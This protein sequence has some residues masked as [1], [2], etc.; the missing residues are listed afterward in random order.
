MDL[1]LII[2]IAVI[3][4]AII[5]FIFGFSNCNNEESGNSGVSQQENS[6]EYQQPE[7]IYY[8]YDNFTYQLI[9]EE[10]EVVSIHNFE[11]K[12]AVL[13]S[14]INGKRVASVKENLFADYFMMND[15]HYR[16][17]LQDW[18]AIHFPSRDSNPLTNEAKLFI[19]ETL[20]TELYIDGF[21]IG[22][23]AFHD[24]LHLTKLT[25]GEGVNSIG[26]WAFSHCFNL[27][28]VVISSNDIII[29]EC[30]FNYCE[31]L[32]SLAVSS[33]VKSFG[34]DCFY[35]ANSLTE[36]N[37]SGSIEE[38]ANIDFANS[39]STPL[40]NAVLYIGGNALHH[41]ILNCEEIKNYAFAHYKPLYSAIIGN[42]V[43][44]IGKN[45][46]Y[47]NS[48]L[49]HVQIG[50][51]VEEIQEGAFE[52]CYRL[53]EVVN[54]S[55]LTIEKGNATQ[56]GQIGANAI[57]VYNGNGEYQSCLSESSGVVYLE[58]GTEFIAVSYVG[59]QSQVSLMTATTKIANYAFQDCKNIEDVV[60]DKFITEV[61]KCAFR[62][63]ENLVSFSCGGELTSIGNYAFEK[64]KKLMS[65][66]LKK[67]ATIGAFCFQYCEGLKEIEFLKG[68]TMVNQSAFAYCYLLE[69]IAM[70]STLEEI[71]SAA[72]YDC[73][74]LKYF[75]YGGNDESWN[76]VIVKSQNECLLNAVRMQYTEN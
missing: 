42:N 34:K 1:K 76:K 33:G 19:N 67:V 5:F 57:A 14:E 8:S 29:G 74:S 11:Q 44:K 70:P 54:R 68:L 9:D 49:M 52:R 66:E 25:V 56:N 72:F 55:L 16:G 6:S 36:V 40:R 38:W 63:C 60:C 15:L 71:G 39:F 65:V 62:N 69:R 12:S 18:C 22:D 64:C 23:F 45:A 59:N 61:G 51:G 2:L 37:Y 13:L 48:F 35:S 73:N 24:Y 7:N 41:V 32:Q 4:M 20:V 31:S 53:V 46:F 50:E 27:R 30:A 17:A 47:E 21:N 75:Q 28:E 26:D 43:A 58:D 3:I 10:Y